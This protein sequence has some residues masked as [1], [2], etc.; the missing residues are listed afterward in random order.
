MQYVAYIEYQKAEEGSLVRNYLQESDS[1]G[2]SQPFYDSPEYNGPM[3]SLDSRVLKFDSIKQVRDVLGSC[4]GLSTR[5]GYL[6]YGYH[7]I[8]EAGNAT[9]PFVV[10]RKGN[11]LDTM[12]AVAAK[13]HADYQQLGRAYVDWGLPQA[14]QF[15]GVTVGRDGDFDIEEVFDGVHEYLINQLDE[16]RDAIE[17]GINA[18]HDAGWR[19]TAIEKDRSIAIIHISR[20]RNGKP[21]HAS[22]QIFCLNL[23]TEDE[24][25]EIKETA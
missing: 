24:L 11:D 19:F 14:W 10:M 23:M 15:N 12:R 16:D 20:V 5:H 18:L 13:A 3:C 1:H 8:T 25:A 6:T 22:A 21:E 2:M 17:V 7:G 4:I 9:T